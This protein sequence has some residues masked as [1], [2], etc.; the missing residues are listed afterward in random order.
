MFTANDPTHGTGLVYSITRNLSQINGLGIGIDPATGILGLDPGLTLVTG[1]VNN[2]G[3]TQDTIISFTVTI[4]ND[5]IDG[6][7]A[8]NRLGTAT[9]LGGQN[10]IDV[11]VLYKPA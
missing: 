9:T 4:Q 5:P 8:D 2:A 10:S 7:N 3:Y 11:Y 6:E 1:L